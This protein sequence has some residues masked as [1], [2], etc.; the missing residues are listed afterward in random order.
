V[1]FDFTYSERALIYLGTLPTKIRKQIIKK[2]EP[3][4]DNPLPP[5]HKLIRGSAGGEDRVYRIRSGDY[6][7]LYEV[8]HSPS[9]IV[10]LDINHRKDIYK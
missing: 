6:R 4:A 10:V 9:Q 8:R 5:K 7:I 3:L 2:I 1:P